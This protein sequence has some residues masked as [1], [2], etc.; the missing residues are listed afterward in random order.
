MLVSVCLAFL[1]ESGL[2]IYTCLFVWLIF[3]FFYIWFY[4]IQCEAISIYKVKYILKNKS[5]KQ[6]GDRYC[7]KLKLFLEKK[8]DNQTEPNI[9]R[10]S[11]CKPYRL[12]LYL[13][14]YD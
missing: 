12:P 3:K 2:Y 14:P 1:Q 7:K 9:H 13:L 6:T 5:D 11:L 8:P 4:T 10:N